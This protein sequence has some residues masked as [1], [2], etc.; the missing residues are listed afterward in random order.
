[1]SEVKLNLVDAGNTL[2]GEVHGSFADRCVAAL[3]AEPE[4]LGELTSA[5]ARYQRPKDEFGP[6]VLFQLSSQVDPTLW[7]AGL[8]VI[9]LAARIVLVDSTYSSP[10]P[11]GEVDYHDGSQ[12]TE[13]PIPYRL[14]D[15][16]LFVNSIEAYRWSRDRRREARQT[17]LPLDTRAVLY[18][19]PLLD[20]IAASTIDLSEADE[21][22]N[23]AS[24][25]LAKQIS[26][27]HTL[28]LMTPRVDLGARCP[29][30]VILEKQ[31]LIDFDLHTRALQWSFQGEGPPCLPR[32][33]F[34]FR[35][36]GFGTHEWVV[37][38]DLVRHLLC[39]AVDIDCRN[40]ETAISKLEKM[41]TSW[42]ENSCDD[43]DG[44]VPTIIIEN[45]RKRLPQTMSAKEMIIDENCD[46]C[47]MSA[48]DLEMGFGPGFWHLDGCNMDEGFVF[49]HF[50]TL[51]E[52]EAEQRE[53]EEFTRKFERE[54]EEWK[55]GIAPVEGVDADPF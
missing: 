42:L 16:W 29:R 18:G 8:V 1:M 20:F 31:N 28:W 19:E 43:Y 24:E 48:Q 40:R 10:G 53:W 26:A 25:L 14:P 49:S 52:W 55:R 22:C 32:D 7:D 50:R 27:I 38:Y 54:K 5:L 37:Y 21:N 30:E 51:A 46:W 36:A 39:S 15:D 9:D 33:S 34:A 35:F 13:C 23:G 12:A 45:E 11:E 6:F 4:T 41:K 47:R 2:V 3:S 17:T 44:R